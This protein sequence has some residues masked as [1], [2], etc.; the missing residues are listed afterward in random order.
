M[1]VCAIY[2]QIPESGS[3]ALMHFCAFLSIERAPPRHGSQSF[4]TFAKVL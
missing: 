1:P 3:L 2:T 4:N